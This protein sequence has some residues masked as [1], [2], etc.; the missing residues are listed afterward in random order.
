MRFHR[1]DR[2]FPAAPILM[3]ILV[4]GLMLVSASA[5][6]ARGASGST[7][8]ASAPPGV[9]GGAAPTLGTIAGRSPALSTGP[10]GN[11]I[12]S[13]LLN[14]NS[15]WPHNFA[16]S[17][18]DWSVGPGAYVPSTGELWL[19]NNLTQGIPGPLPASAPAILYDP[20]TNAFAGIAPQLTNTSDLLYDA[21]NGLLYS[22]NPLND[23]VGVFNP[24]T[25]QWAH[26]AIPVGSY[27]AALALDPAN[28]SLFVANAG[29]NNISVIDTLNQT[30][31]S[32]TISTGANPDSLA[33]D[34][35]DS[36]LFVACAG[37]RMLYDVNTTSYGIS[38]AFP[39]IGNAGEV[40]VSDRSGN[41][42][43]TVP[44]HMF[45]IVAK[46]SSFALVGAPVVGMNSQL[47][48]TSPSA[49][50][51]VVGAPN[52][53]KLVTVNAS[54]AAVI[55]SSIPVGA[56]PS[57]FTGDSASGLV[58]SWSSA[59]RNLTPVEANSSRVSPPSPTLGS[60]PM[61][62]AYDPSTNRI[63]V[64]E[65]LTATI[66]VL[67]ATTF[68]SVRSPIPLP[69]EPYALVDNPE[70]RML[71]AG[72]NNSVIAIDPASG[73]SSGPSV[74]L[75]GAN[76]PLV[77]DVPDGLLWDQ[78]NISGLVA[79]RL[80]N[81]A[82]AFSPGIGAGLTG[83]QS[84]ALDP[85]TDQLY[86]IVPGGGGVQVAV[87]DANDGTV[88]NPGINA[89]SNLTSL[90]YDR[91]DGAVYAL[92]Q[93][94]TMINAT[95]LAVIGS[96]I[97]LPPHTTVG[98]S[99]AYDP[100]RKFLY[101]TTPTDLTSPGHITVIDGTTSAAG[102]GPTAT[103]SVGFGPT[104]ILPY[105]LPGSNSSAS[106]I[107]LVAHNTGGTLGVI[108]TSPPRVDFFTASP[109]T[110]DLGQSTQLILQFSGG[111]GPST[112]SFSG[113]PNGCVSMNAL[114]LE[115]TPSASGTYLIQATITDSLGGMATSTTPLSVAAGLV[116]G[117][118]FSLATF[119]EL[120]TNS[121]FTATAQV[122]NGTPPDNFSWSFGD[123][124]SATGLSAMHSYSSPGNY[125]LSLLVTD[126]L[127]ATGSAGWVVQVNP[128][129]SIGVT[130][131]ARV[132]DVNR[133]VS[134]TAQITGGTGT[135]FT[136]WSFGDGTS[137]NGTAVVHSWRL[138]G[139]HFVTASYVDVLGTHQ[140]S[141]INLTVNPS[142]IGQFSISGG[143]SNAPPTVG[144]SLVFA[145][146][147]TGGTP[148]YSV[149]WNFGDGSQATGTS[150]THAYATQGSYVVNV[151][152]SDPTGATLNGT[153]FTNVVAPVPSPT[154]SSGSSLGFTEGLFLGLLA[155]AVI[156]AIVV[157]ALGPRRPRQR[158][159][160]PSPYVPPTS[161]QAEWQED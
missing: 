118:N 16:S 77:V 42:A 159:S 137:G 132:T 20:S 85:A 25:D 52:G 57:A 114:R 108:A 116:V 104:A 147:P 40:A 50:Q 117:A 33:F 84:M 30:R 138:A 98:G 72:L 66:S 54:S 6:P 73:N 103:I 152:V 95:S 22:A 59:D 119:P 142:L 115:C 135:G 129:P 160:P 5:L 1:P 37:S 14:Y 105:S 17:V 146:T 74:V 65:S 136:T 21:A 149:V 81:L 141:T 100:S 34:A 9:H 83:I 36:R 56:N 28:H 89:G 128:S 97:P 4:A 123:G 155:G 161:T 157:F 154:P 68:R 101:A 15:S 70:G 31:I 86:V 145:A 35:A 148:P 110:I 49:E 64:A 12:T 55:S 76:G 67:N 78:N 13:P 32:V 99:I 58:Y 111:A 45:M 126:R 38:T 144:E 130:A 153:L 151:T 23:T 63:F 127:G 60:R 39:L 41:F 156:A 2:A 150:V 109:Q 19:S 106:D 88:V 121:L 26:A 158:P 3:A 140:N 8:L 10:F 124:S 48:I 79:Y 94:L 7:S 122:T 24:S 43:V 134:F 107:V 93:N 96:A 46:S 47:V 143:N 125:L 29:S 139:N 113:L 62:T 53:A 133:T 92:G 112:V 87:V 131:S 69:S 44:S 80:S 51:F 75:G 91:A 61:A 27:P 120:D 18:W 82:P 71:F 90:A 11:V 102:Y